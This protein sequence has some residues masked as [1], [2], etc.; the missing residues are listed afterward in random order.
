MPRDVCESLVPCDTSDPAGPYPCIGDPLYF[1]GGDDGCDVTPSG[2]FTS[3][4]SGTTNH[5]AGEGW[6]A[7]DLDDHVGCTASPAACWATCLDQYGDELV[8]IDWVTDG[9]CFCQNS[10]PCMVDVGANEIYLITRDSAVSVLPHG[11]TCPGDD[12][13]PQ[14]IAECI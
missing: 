2:D 11:E 10:C 12:G 3:S 7:S 8:A 1:P 6:C 5:G 14:C 9:S 13:P 4:P